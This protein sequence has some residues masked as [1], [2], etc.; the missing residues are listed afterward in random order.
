MSCE[1]LL[2][3]AR[4]IVAIERDPKAAKTSKA[5]LMATAAGISGNPNLEVVQKEVLTWLRKGCQWSKKKVSAPDPEER[6]NLV[7]FDPPYG[8]KLYLPVLKEL[9][10]GN[11]LKKDSIVLCEH[12]SELALRT[13]SNWIEIDRRKYGSSSLLLISP[14]ENYS[15]CTDSKHLQTSQ[16]ELQE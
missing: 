4:R 14:Q 10:K 1:A 2:H 9:L 13:P 15:F 12:S 8:S 3:G 16:E 7:Y 11:W 6:F 5:N